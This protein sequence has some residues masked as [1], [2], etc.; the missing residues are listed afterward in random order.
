M[1]SF[2]YFY[3]ILS[4]FFPFYFIFIFLFFYAYYSVFT[5]ISKFNVQC[6][7]TGE[8][9]HKNNNLLLSLSLHLQSLR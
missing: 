4:F 9:A 2:K 8:V 5:F 3:I 7:S 1:I 6:T